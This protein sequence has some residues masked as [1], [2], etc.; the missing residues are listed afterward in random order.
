M[1][2]CPE[3]NLIL[4]YGPE[5]PPY[6]YYYCDCG[7]RDKLPEVI[8]PLT[9]RNHMDL[10]KLFQC[11]NC[12]DLQAQLEKCKEQKTLFWNS[13]IENVK[14]VTK[15]EEQLQAKDEQLKRMVPL[16]YED[17]QSV[18]EAKDQELKM[19]A[20]DENELTTKLE[21]YGKQIDEQKAEIAR[22]QLH[23]NSVIT[24][25]EKHGCNSITEEFILA[26]L[27]RDD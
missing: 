6:T 13:N 16:T 20:E 1:P 22:L 9:A 23:K 11:K 15:L 5:K 24:Y 7:Y 17:M 14:D 26:E 27:K 19:Y 2:R 8:M 25:L 3:C 21:A 18:I 4:K 10:H 12:Q